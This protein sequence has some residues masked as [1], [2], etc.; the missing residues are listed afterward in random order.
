MSSA[1][2][3]GYCGVW[4]GVLGDE[5]LADSGDEYV[6]KFGGGCFLGATD[7]RFESPDPTSALSST[8]KLLLDSFSGTFR[9]VFNAVLALEAFDLVD[10]VD[11]SSLS[12]FILLDCEVRELGLR[13][14]SSSSCI[15]DMRLGVAFLC[16]ERSV[17]GGLGGLP[18]LVTLAARGVTFSADLD[19]GF[20][21]VPISVESGV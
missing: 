16:C 14:S 11:F 5:S 4:V 10:S 13:S 6:S 19:R 7:V 12:L 20:S 9:G 21:S 3:G 1:N 15:F 2:G 8:L 18:S 17:S